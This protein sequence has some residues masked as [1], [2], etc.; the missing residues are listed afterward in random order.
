MDVVKSTKMDAFEKYQSP[1]NFKIN[2][3]ADLEIK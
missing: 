3:T 1:K 2:F